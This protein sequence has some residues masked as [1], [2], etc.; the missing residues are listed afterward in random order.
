MPTRR[1]QM[2]LDTT[3]KL[4]RRDARKRVA[5]LLEKIHP[6][7]VATVIELLPEKDRRRVFELTG[8]LSRMAEVAAELTAPVAAQVLADH[9]PGELA[10]LCRKMPF[11]DVADVLQGYPEHIVKET[12][13]L[14]SGEESQELRRLM[15]YREDTAGGLMITDFIAFTETLTVEETL[16]RMQNLDDAV[17]VTQ[18]VYVVNETGQL[19]GVASL[20]ELV[21]ADRN[22][23][24]ADVMT[25]NVQ[26]VELNTDQEEIA[27]TIQQYGWLALP[28]VDDMRRLVGVVTVD[29]VIDVI[30]EEAT[31]D[32]LRMAGVEGDA[33]QVLDDGPFVGF[34]RRFPWILGSLLSYVVI[35]RVID[36]FEG[37]LT[38][39]VQLAAFMPVISGMSGN[40]GQQSATM[41]VRAIALGRIDSRA[42]GRTVARQA[43]IGLCLGAVYGL[44]VGIVAS[45]E[46]ERTGLLTSIVAAAMMLGMTQA[47]VLGTAIPMLLDRLGFDPAVA[48]GPI[49]TTLMD[50]FAIVTYLG[51]A[52]MLLTAAGKSP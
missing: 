41:I 37:T 48:T 45:L 10:E 39:F 35:T 1:V 36:G 17:E 14:M 9:T 51:L 38:R 20:R 34:R 31:E 26:S 19:T 30:R 27:R 8:D 11:D 33:E 24:L 47:A 52:T 50:L 5:K 28:V 2:L 13:G 49:V 7:D 44:L 18:Y 43:L 23:T 25:R 42:I 22:D 46:P 3:E 29:D 12:L 21:T 32:M 4:L 15:G 16:R 40:V 6:A